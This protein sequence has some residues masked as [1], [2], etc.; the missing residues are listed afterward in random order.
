MTA[1]PSVGT[2][3]ALTDLVKS[4]RGFTLGPVSTTIRCGVTALLGANGAGKT[5]LMRLVVG[6][7]R[8]SSGQVVLP[9]RGGDVGFLPQDFVGPS[10]ATARDYLG[11]VAWC[12]STRRRKITAQQVI[13]ALAA[14]GLEDRADSRIGALSGGM[15]RRLGIAQALL[16]DAPVLV[17]DEPTVGLDPIQRHEVRELIERLGRH[18]TVLVSTHLAED[19]AAVADHV[20]VLDSGRLL[21]DGPVAGLC[22]GP[23]VTSER[24]EAGFLRLVRGSEPNDH[25]RT[26]GHA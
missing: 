26:S 12:R 24:L 21:H 11:Y 19:V 22:D 6:T 18:T 9:G 8:A 2:D 20:L 25:V 3:V 15:V 13:T 17:L 5:T 14:V 4:Y 23:D 10:R 7:V 1:A 16:A